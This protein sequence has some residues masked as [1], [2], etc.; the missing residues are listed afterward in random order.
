MDDTSYRIL[1]ILSR[2]LGRPIS[3]NELTK[4]IDE[5]HR[6]AYYANI[7]ERIQDLKRQK[8]IAVIKAGRSS[9]LSL[10][11]EN[12]LI[13]DMLAEMELKRKQDFLRE[14][15][16]FAM[17]MLEVDTYLRDIPLIK[18]ISLM[19]PEKN[20]KLNRAEILIQLRES[21]NRGIIEN[22][23]IDIHSIIDNLQ[24]VRNSRID[25]VILEYEDFLNLLKSDEINPIREMLHNKIVILHPQDF[26]MTTKIAVENGIKIIAEKDETNPAKIIEEDLVFNLARFGYTELGP[27]IKQGRLICLEYIISKIMLSKDERRTDAVSIILAKNKNTNYDLL[28]FLGRK[29]DFS[30]K[31][32]GILNALRSLVVHNMQNIEEPIKLLEAMKIE[33]FKINTKNLKEK[34]RLYNVIR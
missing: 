13:T 28:L 26:W 21:H 30:G 18:S 3:I 7:H 25:Y 2:N 15:Q 4:K 9:L 1:D 33:E 12:Y 10:N 29:F 16:E 23:K 31:I 5:I 22:T 34:L 19:Y 32:L 6:G 14:K 27:K 17:L 8:I 20:A 11:F 24:K